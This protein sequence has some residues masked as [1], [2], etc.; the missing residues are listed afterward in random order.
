MCSD[1]A[2]GT[3]CMKGALLSFCA[4]RRKSVQLEFVAD[5]WAS[6]CGWGRWTHR[7]S[8]RT[9]LVRCCKGGSGGAGMPA[10]RGDKKLWIRLTWS[11]PA[12][13]ADWMTVVEK[14]GHNMWIQCPQRHQMSCQ[15]KLPVTHRAPRA[16]DVTILPFSA[17][18]RH[19]S[20]PV[21][22]RAWN[23]GKCC[24]RNIACGGSLLLWVVGLERAMPFCGSHKSVVGFIDM[25]C[26]L[27]H[28]GEF[29]VPWVRQ[30]SDSSSKGLTLSHLRLALCQ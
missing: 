23:L 25:S 1:H 16:H 15:L 24:P 17:C 21:E 22:S 4:H 9:V 26:T 11:E 19:I 18:S 20:R 13:L 29:L 10:L 8:C 7:D 12:T 27:R 5:A 3:G 6:V 14:G 28:P 30:N 2:W